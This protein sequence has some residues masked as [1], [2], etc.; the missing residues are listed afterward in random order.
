MID[1]S[2]VERSILR[3]FKL[4]SVVFCQA[5]TGSF[6]FK[7]VEFSYPTRPHQRILKGINLKVAAGQ[8][9]ALVGSS[10]CG[11][12]TVL[13]LLQRY[14]DPD[15]GTIVSLKRSAGHTFLALLLNARRM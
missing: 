6:S 11:K 3:T 5:A 9:V 2:E 14:Y 15:S 4:N 12:S 8:T 13:Q 1:R 10:G 7:D